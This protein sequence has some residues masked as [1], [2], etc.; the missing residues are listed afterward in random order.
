MIHRSSVAVRRASAAVL[1]ATV[2]GAASC[3]GTTGGATDATAPTSI[4]SSTTT[5]PGP[6]STAPNG[7]DAPVTPSAEAVAANLTIA[8]LGPEWIVYPSDAP[9]SG[10]DDEPCPTELD[11]V[12][13]DANRAE[14]GVL[15]LGDR[16][17][18]VASDSWVFP[19][20]AS[21]QAFLASRLSDT[22]AECR[23]A[24]LEEGADEREP[25]VYVVVDAVVPSDGTVPYQ[26]TV[27]FAAQEEVDGVRQAI[28]S[29][30][31]NYYLEGTT[32]IDVFEQQF[33]LADDPPDLSERVRGEVDAAMIIVVDRVTG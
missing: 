22:Y 10:D 30:Q 4:P 8:D 18:F 20:I 12:V 13:D 9:L 3:S 25:R 31:H 5:T 27:G 23:R 14:S 24:D 6:G 11:D 26:G 16:T 17:R 2:L 19:D 29:Y 28:G 15:Q 1:L 33:A 32:V 21:A 7:T